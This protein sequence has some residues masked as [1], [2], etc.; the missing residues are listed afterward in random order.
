MLFLIGMLITPMPANADRGRSGDDLDGCRTRPHNLLR[1]GF[2]LVACG[3]SSNW[4]RTHLWFHWLSD[5]ARSYDV[6]VYQEHAYGFDGII[7]TC[8]DLETGKRKWK[9]GRYDKGQV[10]LLE[11]SG[12]LLVASEKGEAVLLKA[13]PAKRVELGKVKAI[14]GKTW[15]HPVVVGDRL[16]IRNGQEAA[17]LRLSLAGT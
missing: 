17:C 8:I 14:D 12:L 9:G 4:S 3:Q 7:F 2:T 16:Y 5:L 1:F 6:A 11:D 13:N 15:N 10:L